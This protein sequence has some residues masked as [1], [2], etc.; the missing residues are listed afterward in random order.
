M[1]VSNEM[2]HLCDVEPGQW[3]QII[4]TGVVGM[5]ISDDSAKHCSLPAQMKCYYVTAAGELKYDY[6]DEPC[7]LLIEQEDEK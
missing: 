3:C 1:K 5:R 6:R 2:I 4:G 7:N